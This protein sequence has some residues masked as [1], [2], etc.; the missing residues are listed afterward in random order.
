MHFA[1][2]KLLH[3]FIRI[4][5]NL[6]SGI[7]RTLVFSEIFYNKLKRFQFFKIMEKLYIFLNFIEFFNIFMHLY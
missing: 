6:F 7:D 5:R 4:L 1:K 2:I 3:N